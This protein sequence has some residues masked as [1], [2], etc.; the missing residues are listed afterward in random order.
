MKKLRR[1]A[2]RYQ[3]S[4]AA[5]GNYIPSMA[6]AIAFVK[7]VRERNGDNNETTRSNE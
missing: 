5:K 2:I 6:E 3:N 1:A 4:V 7:R